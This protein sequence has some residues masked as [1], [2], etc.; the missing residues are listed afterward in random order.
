MFGDGDA[1]GGG[2]EGD[3]GGDVEGVRTVAAGAAGVDEGV[4]LSGSKGDGRGGLLDGGEEA[5]EFVRGFAAGVEGGKEGG[6]VVFGVAPLEQGRHEV[7]GRVLLQ[8]VS[9][10][11]GEKSVGRHLFRLFHFDWIARGAAG[12]GSNFAVE[13]EPELVGGVAGVAGDAE[14]GCGVGLHVE[15]ERREEKSHA[16]AVQTGRRWANSAWGSMRVWCAGGCGQGQWEAG[17]GYRA[18]RTVGRHR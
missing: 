9:E 10:A 7:A 16:R 3:G 4:A 1:G 5:G 6:D 2:D 8:G 11:N 17:P 13:D 15:E 12:C 18:L 14:I